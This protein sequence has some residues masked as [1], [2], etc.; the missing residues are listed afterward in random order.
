MRIRVRFGAIRLVSIAFACARPELHLAPTRLT[1]A[2]VQDRVWPRRNRVEHAREMSR[3]AG[4]SA[5]GPDACIRPIGRKKGDR[6]MASLS[7]Y[8][9]HSGDIT[10]LDRHEKAERRLGMVIEGRWRLDRVV[11]S[12]GMGAVYRAR[13]RNGRVAAIKVMHSELADRAD[14]R[15][16]FF[17]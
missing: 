11:G 16:R 15:E 8:E 7:T 1:V 14:L 5:N 17:T 2:R 3:S 4:S 6:N 13:H 12:G 10:V 9:L